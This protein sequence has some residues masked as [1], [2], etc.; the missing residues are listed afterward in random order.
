MNTS[1]RQWQRG[2]SFVEVAISLPIILL[3]LGGLFD[4]GRGVLIL[5]AV[6][7]AAGEGAIYATVHPECLTT[8]HA[9]TICQDD[10]SIAGRVRA[11]GRPVINMDETNSTI[12]IY[13]KNGAEITAGSTVIVNVIYT[14]TPLTPIGHLLWGDVAQVEAQAEQEILSPPPPG[15]QY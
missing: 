5:I 7:S 10:A 8:D 1:K 14:Y 4:I 2:Q 15:Y 11:E 6:E 9:P 3:I 13:V 12:T